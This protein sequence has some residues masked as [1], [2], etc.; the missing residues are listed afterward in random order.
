MKNSILGSAAAVAIAMMDEELMRGKS[1]SKTIADEFENLDKAFDEG[2]KIIDKEFGV[3]SPEEETN[4]VAEIDQKEKV[5]E[6]ARKAA[7]EKKIRVENTNM[8][9]ALEKRA[10]KLARRAARYAKDPGFSRG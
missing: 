2:N 7:I 3:L 10:A 1:P 6:E 5:R 4:L 9:L 8:K